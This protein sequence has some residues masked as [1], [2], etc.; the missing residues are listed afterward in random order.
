MNLKTLT[1]SL[2]LLMPCALLAMEGAAE[3]TQAPQNALPL[4][5]ISMILTDCNSDP[6]DE[7][8]QSRTERICKA[9]PNQKG[10]YDIE[11]FM[12]L[13]NRL[14]YVALLTSIRLD[15][16]N[17]HP[18]ITYRLGDSD[19]PKEKMKYPR[20][21]ASDFELS[22]PYDNPRTLDVELE[23]QTLNLKILIKQTN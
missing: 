8:G 17:P 4:I 1:L 3:T 18:V 10:G 15:P 5:R 2:S 20:H 19:A 21:E 13:I 6:A 22:V 16:A 11:Q 9:T 23:N 14:D 12:Y 7:D